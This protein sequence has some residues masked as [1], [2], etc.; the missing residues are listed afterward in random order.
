[1]SSYVVSICSIDLN[2]D[3]NRK[4]FFKILRFVEEKK[5]IQACNAMIKWWQNFHFW[6]NYSFELP[7]DSDYPS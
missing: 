1:M 6:A 7:A 5:I 4:R 3:K 2:I